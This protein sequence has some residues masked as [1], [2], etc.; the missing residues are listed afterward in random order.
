[1]YQH[2]ID[3]DPDAYYPWANNLDGIAIEKEEIPM[4]TSIDEQMNDYQALLDIHVSN[5]FAAAVPIIQFML[6]EGFKV[7]NSIHMNWD[8]IQGIELFELDWK[9]DRLVGQ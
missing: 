4:T 2:L 8:G 1:M 7:F 9:E 3:N 6:E 5:E